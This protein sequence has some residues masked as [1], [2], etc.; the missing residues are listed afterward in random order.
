MEAETCEEIDIARASI[1]SDGELCEG[2]G[3]RMSDLVV[4]SFDSVSYYSAVSETERLHRSQEFQRHH[5]TNQ[6]R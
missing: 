2:D 3:T 5:V 6:L 1:S 4:G